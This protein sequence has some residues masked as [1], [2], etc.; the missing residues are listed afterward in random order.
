MYFPNAR[1]NYEN[2]SKIYYMLKLDIIK[3]DYFCN[4]QFRK[5]PWKFL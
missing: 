5:K 2:L 4:S 1:E 3:I